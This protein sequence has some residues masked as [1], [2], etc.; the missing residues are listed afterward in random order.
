LRRLPAT[1]PREYAAAVEDGKGGWIAGR[2][3]ALRRSREATR[4]TRKREQRR[5]QRKGTPIS[6]ASLE[7]A[8]YFVLWT[9]LPKTVPMQQVLELYRLRWQIGLVFKRMKSILGLGHLPKKDPRSA[10]AWLEG[11]L[12]VGL[13]IERTI[14]A[15]RSF[16][17]WGYPLVGPAQP[18]A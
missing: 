12:F 4:R 10:Q 3:I 9:N 2:C 16:S 13:L 5:A 17:P 7:Y 1:G 14:D 11:K 6:A 8:Q 15:A 18:L